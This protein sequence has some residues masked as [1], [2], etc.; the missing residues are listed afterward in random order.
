VLADARAALA[1][2]DDF[3][4]AGV[5]AALEGVLERLAL[6]PRAVYQPV[7][8][9]ISGT[10]ISPGIFETAALLGR[11]DVLARIERALNL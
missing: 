1:A 3:D 6:K 7:R 11:D 10:A 4:Q 5:Q 9:A 2:L 8:V